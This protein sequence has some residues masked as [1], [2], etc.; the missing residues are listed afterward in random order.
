MSEWAAYE[1]KLWIRD[2][3]VVDSWLPLVP[4]GVAAEPRVQLGDTGKV[5][6]GLKIKSNGQCCW[7]Y[8]I[9]VIKLLTLS[10]LIFMTFFK[11]FVLWVINY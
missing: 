3:T 4:A 6:V 8:A 5:G 9:K 7:G 1:L 10:K 2:G 11:Y